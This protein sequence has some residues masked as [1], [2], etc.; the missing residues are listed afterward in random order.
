ML[1]CSGGFISNA[2]GSLLLATHPVIASEFNALD[3]SSWLLTSFA[4]AL[5]AVMPL[6]GKLSDIYGRKALLLISYALFSLGL[7]FVGIGT[8]MPHLIVGRVIS[9]AGA[10]GMT[11]LVSILITDLVPLREVASWRS[12]VNVVAT[13]GRSIGGPLGGWLADTVG[14]RWSFLLQVPFAILAM[15]LIAVILPTEKP[16]IREDTQRSK[17]ARIDFTGATLMTLAILS[18]LFPLEIGGVKVAWSS[19][20]ILT[21]LGS[22]LAF[23]AL[24]IASQAYWAKEPIMPLDLLS[25]RD[26]LTSIIIMTFQSSAQMGVSYYPLVSHSRSDFMQLMFAVPLYFQITARA[27]NTVAG[28]HLAPAVVGNAVGGILSGIIIKRYAFS[29]V[30]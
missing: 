12:Y 24:F 4:I 11:T 16:H 29:P 9:G 5:A 26:V 23:G 27:S 6:Y 15:V 10:S 28:A 20:I 7:I 8:S 17:F 25:N 1:N 30:Y 21:L 2:D 3:D 13:T 22:G 14:W 18:F 19:P